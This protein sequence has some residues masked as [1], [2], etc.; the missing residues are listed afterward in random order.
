MV[1]VGH[2]KSH[3]KTPLL[4]TECQEP[5]DKLP[6][7]AMLVQVFPGYLLADSLFQPRERADGLFGNGSHGRVHEFFLYFLEFFL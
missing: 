1:V 6:S 4:P 2:L 7:K 3:D 5:G